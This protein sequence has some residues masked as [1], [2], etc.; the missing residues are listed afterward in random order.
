VQPPVQPAAGCGVKAAA[1]AAAAAEEEKE[2]E[3]GQ[4]WWEGYDHDLLADMLFITTKHDV[5]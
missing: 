3:V 4:V 5:K 1:A 2:E